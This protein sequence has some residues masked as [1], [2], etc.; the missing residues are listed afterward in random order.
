MFL[1]HKHMMSSIDEYGM[2]KVILQI[3]ESELKLQINTN[4]YLEGGILSGFLGKNMDIGRIEDTL[5]FGRINNIDIRSNN[6][7]DVITDLI[8]NA[9]A[10]EYPYYTI[11]WYFPTKNTPD[12]HIQSVITY[13]SATDAI[14]MKIRYLGGHHEIVFKE[15]IC[16]QTPITDISTIYHQKGLI[17]SISITY[18]LG[19]RI[20]GG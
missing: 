9:Q 15:S 13:V 2:R 7:D 19:D 10:S 1:H 5:W 11:N 8:L 17:W 18:N 14:Y 3:H 12:T 4:T 6:F 20:L 16:T